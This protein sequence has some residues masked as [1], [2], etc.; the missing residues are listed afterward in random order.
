MPGAHDELGFD[1]YV[2]R[3]GNGGGV[4]GLIAES[5]LLAGA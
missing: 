4:R 3:K 1:I 2:R 5:R